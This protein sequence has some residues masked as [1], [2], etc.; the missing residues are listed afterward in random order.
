MQRLLILAV[1]FGFGFFSVQP[2]HA[3][4]PTPGSP[5]PTLD[6]VAWAGQGTNF[7]ALKGKTVVVL[8]YVTWCP[9]CNAWSGDAVRGLSKAI[10][11]KP[12]V[13]LA[14]S[15]D[16]PPAKAVAYMEERKFVGPNILHG[17][18]RSI[19]KRLG[20]S[21][22]FFNYAI[23]GPDSSVIA[24]GNAGSY[25]DGDGGKSFVMASEIADRSDLGKFRFLTDDMSATLKELIFPMELGKFPSAA[26]TARLKRGLKADDRQ[27]FDQMINKFLDDQ[28]ESA[29]SQSEGEVPEKLA[30]F[31]TATFLASTFKATD[32]GKKAKKLLTD[33]G[34]NKDLKN[35][36][37]AKKLYDD[38]LKL[39]GGEMSRQATML[40]TVT[41][42]FPGTHYAAIANDLAEDNL[43][44]L[45]EK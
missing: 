40:R 32:Q 25:R 3:D 42:K 5:P 39:A 33:L 45:E 4:G 2:V 24:A 35:E 41:K 16:T 36:L 9:K 21:N 28:L 29:T 27:A 17:Y 1:T 43:K 22:E 31:E 14:I 7:A 15:T 44:A 26:D 11:D 34:R 10:A 12:V 20:F 18:D 37:A 19:A 38:V 6:S 8:T 30:A 23:I 13:V